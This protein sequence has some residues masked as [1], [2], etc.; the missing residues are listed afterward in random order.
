L[1]KRSNNKKKYRH[2]QTG[3]RNPKSETSSAAPPSLNLDYMNA[4][5]VATDDWKSVQIVV[6]GCGGIGAYV[7]QHIGRLI[8]VLQNSQHQVHLSLCDPDVVEEKNIGRQLF[9]QAEVGESKAIALARRYGAAWGL[10]TA[11]YPEEFSERF[12][13]PESDLIVIVGCVDNARARQTLHATLEHNPERV[14]TCGPTGVHALPKVWWLD[15]GNL[16]DTGRVMLGTAA[17]PEQCEGAF[18]KRSALIDGRVKS[19]GYCVALPSPALQ[20]PSLLIP[21]RDEQAVPEMSCAELQLAN[22]Q[23]LNINPAIA[24]MANNMLTRLLVTQ[25]LKLYQSVANLASLTV[26]SFYCTPEEIAREIE[27]PV[28]FVMREEASEAAA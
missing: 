26:K 2:L 9:C 8:Y 1:T 27:R 23:S 12:L 24:W 10:N 25:D 20:Y 6:A 22:L 7:V 17:T 14:G 28:E 11:A 16:K 18:V 21:G 4:A 13:S 3:T 5:T 15:C 19:P